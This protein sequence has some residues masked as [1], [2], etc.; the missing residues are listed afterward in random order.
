MTDDLIFSIDHIFNLDQN[1]YSYNDWRTANSPNDCIKYM[2]I[3]IKEK[4]FEIPVFAMPNFLRAANRGLDIGREAIIMQMLSLGRTSRYKSLERIMQDMLNESY[5]SKLVK[6]SVKQSGDEYKTYYL[7]AGAVFDE[8][9]DPVLLCS[10]Q[11]E[12]VFR[13]RER[14]YRIAKPIIWMDPI[15]YIDRSSKMNKFLTDKM[16]AT[17]LTDRVPQLVT[18]HSWS[19]P[20]P[21][22]LTCPR[23]IID[24]CPFKFR[25]TAL[26]SISV[27][28]ERLLKVAI[29]NIDEM[30]NI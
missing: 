23:L 9:F 20:S 22:G 4:F 5:Q 15:E 7:T 27:T 25:Q 6:V 13:M 11:I 21:P 29:D 26:P 8:D 24:E 28:N 30:I 10:W 19:L 16:I 14:K 1:N 12:R 3:P 2:E 18:A 17:L